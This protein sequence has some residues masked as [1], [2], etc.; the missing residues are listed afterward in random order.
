M[1]FNVAWVSALPLPLALPLALLLAAQTAWATG[2]ELVGDPSRGLEIAA[3]RQTGLCV[4]CHAVPGS[5]ERQDSNIG[6]PLAGA[7]TRWTSDQLRE[8]IM[9][10]KRFNPDSVMPAF[11]RVDGLSRVGAAWRDKPI[12]NPQQ[13]E[14]V[15]AWLAGLK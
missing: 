4:L 10:P 15:V 1:K 9:N 8:R 2:T 13:I 12:L 14:D 5:G 11:G 3:S 7:G 6:T